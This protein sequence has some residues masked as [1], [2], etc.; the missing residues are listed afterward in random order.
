MPIRLLY[1][2]RLDAESLAIC[3]ATGRGLYRA[4]TAVLEQPTAYGPAPM[5]V[6]Q[7]V[8]LVLDSSETVAQGKPGMYV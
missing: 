8:E 7:R 6:N 4:K 1:R 3:T 2:R 5:A